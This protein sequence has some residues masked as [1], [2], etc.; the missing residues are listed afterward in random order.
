MGKFPFSFRSRVSNDP[1]LDSALAQNFEKAVTKAELDE[2]IAGVVAGTV[3]DHGALTGLSDDDHPQYHNDARGDLRY[4]QLSTDLA[5]Q[6]ELD[7]EASTRASAD[8]AEATARAAADTALDNRIDPLVSEIM[9]AQDLAQDAITEATNLDDATNRRIDF[10]LDE[11]ADRLD[12][13]IGDAAV[14]ANIDAHLADTTDAHAAS[15]ITNTPAGNVAATTV[16]G[17]INELDSEKA[18]TGSVTTVQANV[19]AEAAARAAADTTLQ[20][21]ITN[22]ATA[23]AAADTDLSNRIDPL[24]S[25]IMLAQD[26]A[27]DAIYE[28]TALDD[29]TNRRLDFELDEK[30]DRL[31]L[32]IHLASSSAHD[33]SSIPIVDAA[34]YY[35]STQVEGALQE[36]YLAQLGNTIAAKYRGAWNAS[37]QYATGDIVIYD[38][39]SIIATSTP[40]LG[41]TPVG[42]ALGGVWDYATWDGTVWAGANGWTFLVAAGADGAPGSGITDEIA[43]SEA[44]LAQDLAQDAQKEATTLADEI[45]RRIDF[46]LEEKADRIHDHGTLYVASPPA[47]TSDGSVITS[48]TA[49]VGGAK[50]VPRGTVSGGFTTRT[51]D[52]DSGSLSSGVRTS[53]IMSIT[54]TGDNVNYMW[55]DFWCAGLYMS[56]GTPDTEMNPELWDGTVGSGTRIC[57]A[58]CITSAVGRPWPFTMSARVAPFSGSKTFSFAILNSDATSTTIRTVSG[59][60]YPTYLLAR[61]D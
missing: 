61:W 28:A 33:A 34:G 17:A 41:A 38:G 45:D 56:G 36:V 51:T 43:R 46:E 8:T 48:D 53:A 58:D 3:T 52:F 44:W 25:E 18:T 23:R 6:A 37:T 12:V 40:T 7:A 26:L 42:N 1:K 30:A 35:T 59:T 49:S 55:V 27:Q 4:W 10:E 19:D 11:K 29:A 50:W 60:T 9:L 47:G 57:L 20:T 15:A 2:Q 32:G 5:T 14:Q 22:E 54:V 24:M 13:A 39:N 16:Q 31:D 21:N